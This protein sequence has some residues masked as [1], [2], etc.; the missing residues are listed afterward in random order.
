M[1]VVDKHVLVLHGPVRQVW[2]EV[3]GALADTGWVVHNCDS[4]LLLASQL[5]QIAGPFVICIGAVESLP[6][7]PERLLA[8]LTERAVDCCFWATRHSS[9]DVVEQVQSFGIPVF[10]RKE[11]FDAWIRR[12]EGVMPECA[13]AVQ[14]EGSVVSDEE[15]AALFGEDLDG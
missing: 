9:W 5:G 13:S 12:L 14:D 11:A 7:R 6:T 15:L 2:H 3:F 8:W 10:T 1:P 4:D